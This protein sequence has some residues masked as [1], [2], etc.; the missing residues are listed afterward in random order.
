MAHDDLGGTGA[1]DARAEGDEER[2]LEAERVLDL[3]RPAMEADA[4]G[5]AI[6]NIDGGVVSVCFRGTCLNCPSI[7]LTLSLGIERT[8][9]QHL[10]WVRHVVRVG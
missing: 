3:V 8:L 2:R 10:P 6:V 4:G 5:V 7:N 1:D 9:K